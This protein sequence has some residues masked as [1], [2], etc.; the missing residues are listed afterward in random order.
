MRRGWTGIS[1]PFR[2]SNRGG[3]AMSSTDRY[4]VPHIRESIE[5]IL[6]TYVG[7]RVMETDLF[8]TIRSFVFEPNDEETHEMLKYEISE[9]IEMHEPRVEVSPDTIEIREE[10]SK[11]YA[12]IGFTVVNYGTKE[13]QVN[14]EIGGERIE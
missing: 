13:Y 9:A 12:L 1:F 10:G 2:L 14:V 7:E 3:V 5:Q 4:D 8:S 11:L 6:S